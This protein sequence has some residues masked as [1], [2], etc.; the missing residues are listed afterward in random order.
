VLGFKPALKEGSI[1]VIEPNCPAVFTV[2]H[3]I[4]IANVVGLDFYSSVSTLYRAL[5]Q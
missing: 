3:L 5:V 1:V 4:Y 2:K